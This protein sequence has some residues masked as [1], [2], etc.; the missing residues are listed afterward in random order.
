MRALILMSRPTNLMKLNL[1]DMDIGLVL[2]LEI[3][4]VI[5]Q[6]YYLR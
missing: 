3:P 1:I 6:I 5:F 4:E 2:Y